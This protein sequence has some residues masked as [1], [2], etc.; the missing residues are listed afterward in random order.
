MYYRNHVYQHVTG[1]ESFEPALSR[2]EQIDHD[3]LWALAQG[4]P[5]EWY[6]HDEAGLAC[7]IEALYERRSKIR[8]LI[9]AFRHSS[10]RPFPNWRDN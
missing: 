6:E 3:A 4:V 10:R 1:W 9:T 5:Q 7:L 2:A 8:A